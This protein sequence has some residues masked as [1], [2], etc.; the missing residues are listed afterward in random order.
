MRAFP[1][2]RSRT[3]LCEHP[4]RFGRLGEAFSPL[5][6][7]AYS[8]RPRQRYLLISRDCF[9][10]SALDFD[11]Q[12]GGQF[13]LH[14]VSHLYEGGCVIV[15]INLGFGE[16]PS[17]DDD[18][19]ARLPDPSL[20]YRRDWHDSWRVESRADDQTTCAR[21]VSPNPDQFR[22]RERASRARRSNWC[23]CCCLWL[24]PPSLVRTSGP[25]SSKRWLPA[26]RRT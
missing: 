8:I 11:A 24:R 17:Q 6:R 26:L 16:R 18:G 20:P 25:L 13:L 7:Q 2:R 1:G 12:S 3:L 4:F 23:R 21:P 14:L 15:T 22:P 10:S 9:G 19:I 5:D